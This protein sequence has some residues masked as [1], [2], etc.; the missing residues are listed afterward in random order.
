MYEEGEREQRTLSPTISGGP[1]SENPQPQQTSLSSVYYWLTMTEKNKSHRHQGRDKYIY[2]WYPVLRYPFE[3][4]YDILYHTQ[5]I[6][7]GIQTV[8]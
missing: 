6:I 3:L 8:L 5:L 4:L 7:L 2:T 1:H